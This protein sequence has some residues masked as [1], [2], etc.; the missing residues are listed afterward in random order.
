M[1]SFGEKKFFNFYP[2]IL[3]TAIDA[4]MVVEGEVGRG[5]GEYR[6]HPRQIS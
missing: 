4:H 3:I 6:T 5:F 1:M 2:S